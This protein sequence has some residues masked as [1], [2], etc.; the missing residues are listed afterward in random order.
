MNSSHQ[1]SNELSKDDTMES[2]ATRQADVRHFVDLPRFGPFHYTDSETLSFPWGIPG[3]SEL[4]HFV[5]L[6]LPSN[7]HVVWL[8][9][10]ERT[11]I[12]IPLTNPW[13][14]YDDYAPVLPDSAR[15]S[16]EITAPDDFALMN[17]LVADTSADETKQYINLL[18]PIVINLK[19]RIGR[20]VMLEGSNYNVR[21]PIILPPSITETE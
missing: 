2:T 15:L 10:I 6:T 7:E 5:A 12:A 3:F 21:T 18:A 8:Q 20:Q 14:I 9:S 13:R 1:S 19:K 17:V 4:R 16:L 11:E